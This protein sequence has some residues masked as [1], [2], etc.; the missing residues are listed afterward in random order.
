MASSIDFAQTPPAKAPKP[1]LRKTRFAAAPASKAPAA[2]PAPPAQSDAPPNPP[3]MTKDAENKALNAVK[4]TFNGK[5]DAQKFITDNQD[6]FQVLT[7]LKMLQ[8]LPD[9]YNGDQLNTFVN[10]LRLSILEI[11]VAHY[12]VQV[13]SSKN[14]KY[15]YLKVNTMAERTSWAN[16]TFNSTFFTTFFTNNRRENMSKWFY[17]CDLILVTLMESEDQLILTHISIQDVYKII[18]RFFHFEPGEDASNVKP[19]RFNKEYFESNDMDY[20]VTLA[21]RTRLVAVDDG[22]SLN[23]RLRR[24]K[25]R[26]NLGREGDEKSLLLGIH[27]NERGL[28]RFSKKDSD[29][30][31]SKREYGSKRNRFFTKHFKKLEEKQKTKKA[32]VVNIKEMID[33]EFRPENADRLRKLK[34]EFWVLIKGKSDLS[35]ITSS[36]R[37]EVWKLTKARAKLMIY[38]RYGQYIHEGFDFDET[39]YD[40]AKYLKYLL[41]KD[42]EENGLE[43]ETDFTQSELYEF[44]GINFKKMVDDWNKLHSFYGRAKLDDKFLPALLDIVPKY[45]LAIKETICHVIDQYMQNPVHYRTPPRR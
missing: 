6:V 11:Y 9:D 44:R 38:R 14:L 30:L 43:D 21:G 19:D 3:K 29:V 7:D 37:E 4:N 18:K 25:S 27:A 13:S 2:P 41:F 8:N 34:D 22:K 23:Y 15:D 26:F 40:H 10:S 35:Q 36:Q 1:I 5:V 12:F 28:I 42:M 33:K 45:A 16:E 32:K 24:L 17:L 20:R 39:K 31:R